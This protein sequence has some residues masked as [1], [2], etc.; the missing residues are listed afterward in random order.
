MSNCHT[1]DH[2]NGHGKQWIRFE[3]FKFGRS[4]HIFGKKKLT[5]KTKDQ[6]KADFQSLLL[7]SNALLIPLLNEIIMHYCISHYF[8]PKKCNALMHYSITGE[9]YFCSDLINFTS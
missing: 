7:K 1:F 9:R 2:S 8:F 3:I 5:E 6:L 4:D